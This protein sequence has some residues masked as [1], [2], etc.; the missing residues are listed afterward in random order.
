MANR[1]SAADRRDEILRATLRLVGRK[2]FAAVTLRDVATEIGVSHGL[3]NHYFPDRNELLAEAFHLAAT[4]EYEYWREEFARDRDPLDRLAEF[5]FPPQRAHYL[6]WLDAWSEA[7]RNHALTRTLRVHHREW[8][9]KLSET[10][11]D[12]VAA[13]TLRCADPAAA[14]RSILAHFDGL[15]VQCF[16]MGLISETT[17]HELS[18]ALIAH[19]VGLEP[20]VLRARPPAPITP[21]ASTPATTKA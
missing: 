12:G 7:P 19:H 8:E 17:Y 14:A 20:A 9:D 2:G 21:S 11:V 6:I 10:I 1:K 18:V 13:G 5:C 4:E 15:A 3:V 16:A